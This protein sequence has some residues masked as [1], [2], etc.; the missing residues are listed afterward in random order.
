MSTT[1]RR[2]LHNDGGETGKSITVSKDKAV[3]TEMAKQVYEFLEDQDCQARPA[4]WTNLS[5]PTKLSVAQ[6]MGMFKFLASHFVGDSYFPRPVE[7]EKGKKIE[8][9]DDDIE[10]LMEVFRILKF[11]GTIQK[12]HLKT[13][14]TSFAWPGCL[15][16]L[17]WLTSRTQALLNPPSER[18]CIAQLSSNGLQEYAFESYLNLFPLHFSNELTNEA[19]EMELE[20]FKVR[21][22]ESNAVELTKT[23]DELI[24][25]RSE[26]LVELEKLNQ[27]VDPS[28][29]FH[30]RFKAEVEVLNSVKGKLQEAENT[31]KHYASVN[32]LQLQQERIGLDINAKAAELL[33]IKQQISDQPLS[34][35]EASALT[36]ETATLAKQ[37]SSI[38][39]VNADLKTKAEGR[40]KAL[41]ACQQEVRNSNTKYDF[42]ILF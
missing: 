25:E 40:R 8:K 11:P 12:T 21:V 3:L 26:R 19:V 1:R 42:S 27:E 6:V 29:E 41:E 14:N 36:S 15:T 2:G 28:K 33:R 7:N 23:K 30:E 32:H 22:R 10:K 20:N 4:N 31:C 18:T 34:R 5:N 35:Q 24:Q 37:L 17:A 13:A 16:A 39:H 38:R 9:L